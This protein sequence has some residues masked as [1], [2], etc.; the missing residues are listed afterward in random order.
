MRLTVIIG[1]V[2]LASV[3]MHVFISPLC[4]CSTKTPSHASA[5]KSG[6]RNL[7]T[8]QEEYLVDH[9]TYADDIAALEFFVGQRPLVKIAILAGDA[10]SWAARATHDAFTSGLYAGADCVTAFGTSDAVPQTTMKHRSPSADRPL[11][12]DMD[13]WSAFQ[14]RWARW[15]WRTSD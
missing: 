12:C 15:R 8:A 6:L 7:A 4:G 3:A 13:G 5:M 1:G 14:S 11:V 10:E 2:L 9:G